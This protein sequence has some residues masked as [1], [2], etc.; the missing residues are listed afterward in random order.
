MTR[1]KRADLEKLEKRERSQEIEKRKE[2]TIVAVLLKG[3]VKV[4]V[5]VKTCSGKSEYFLPEESSGI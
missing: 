2:E 4:V 1:M 3:C 5:V